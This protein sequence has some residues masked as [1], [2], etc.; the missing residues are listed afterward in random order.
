MPGLGNI[1]PDKTAAAYS[2]SKDLPRFGP[3]RF[4]A[5]IGRGDRQAV[6]RGASAETTNVRR[7]GIVDPRV[8]ESVLADAASY[9]HR[10]CVEHRRRD[11]LDVR[12]CIVVASDI[13]LSSVF[14]SFKDLLRSQFRTVEMRPRQSPGTLTLVKEVPASAWAAG[15]GEHDPHRPGHKAVPRFANVLSPD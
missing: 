15:H 6:C 4:V 8:A 7:L 14:C 9:Q 1:A 2:C 10:S 11:Q 5:I 3:F 13:S 12:V